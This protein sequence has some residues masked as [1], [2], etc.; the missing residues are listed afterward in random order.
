MVLLP[1]MLM[2]RYNQQHQSKP[3]KRNS[4]FNSGC[5]QL[6]YVGK[7]CDPPTTKTPNIDNAVHDQNTKKITVGNVSTSQNSLEEFDVGVNDFGGEFFITKTLH[8][9][10]GDDRKIEIVIEP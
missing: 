3:M 7:P 10:P 6:D 9:H 4:V 5:S 2:S 8:Q 1:C